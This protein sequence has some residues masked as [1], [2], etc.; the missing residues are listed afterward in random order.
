MSDSNDVQM[1]E[2]RL[3]ERFF[4]AP[5]QVARFSAAMGRNLPHHRFSGEGANKL[6][7]PQHFVTTIYFDTPSRHQYQAAQRDGAHNSKMRAR[8][9][10]DIHP[11]LAEL[12][13]DARQ[14]V[15]YQPVLWLELK[16]REGTR[17]GKRRVPI[18]K[19]DV[20]AFFAEGAITPE[21]IALQE[22]LHGA[23]G[24]Q[25]LREIARYCTRYG[26]PFRADCLVN[27]RRLPWQD[28]EG[29]VR[30]TLDMGLELFAPP[31]DLWR[32]NEAL[33][34]ESLGTPRRRESRVVAEVKARG[35]PPGWLK[36]LLAEVQ[37][38][39]TRFSKFEEASRAIH[40]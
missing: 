2:D 25:A 1:T 28:P 32:R 8:E 21:M 11:S 33:V 5:E 27:Y 39:P 13:T 35:T 16:V 31:P 3:E 18:P 17:T 40:A 22:S 12:A 19:K 20:P 26:E 38:T 34:R 23:E 30:V 14:I 15:K 29:T 10:Y 36:T 9:Y 37:A 24:E 6:P 7:R 4:I